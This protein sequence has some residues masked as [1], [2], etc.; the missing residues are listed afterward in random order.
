[1]NEKLKSLQIS[2]IFVLRHLRM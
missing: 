2:D 1:L